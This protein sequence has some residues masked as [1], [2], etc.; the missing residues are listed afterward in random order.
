MND[1]PVRRGDLVARH[2]RSRIEP[3]QAEYIAGSSAARSLLAQLRRC[4]PAEPGASP[5]VWEITLADLDESLVGRTGPSAAERSIHAALVLY[6]THQQSNQVPVHVHGTSLGKAVRALAMQRAYEEVLDSSTVKRL[7][8]VG[9]ATSERARIHHLR[10][11]VTLLRSTSPVVGLDYGQ[12]GRDLFTLTLA[13]NAQRVLLRWGRDLHI[14]QKSE[15]Q[16]EE[17]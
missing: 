4:D 8:Q 7:H 11:I 14:T 17:L 16:G 10:G 5:D 13:R 6:A 15:T 9:L 3:L 2:L 12:L 1:E